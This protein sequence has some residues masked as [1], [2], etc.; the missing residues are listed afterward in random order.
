M[1]S[2]CCPACEGVRF[3]DRCGTAGT[4]GGSDQ[5]PTFIVTLERHVFVVSSVEDVSRAS[6]LCWLRV[7][8]TV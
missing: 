1:T 5:G 8:Y 3:G 6:Y 4:T 7:V 2:R